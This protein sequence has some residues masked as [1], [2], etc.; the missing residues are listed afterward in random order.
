MEGKQAL[1]QRPILRSRSTRRT[2][3]AKVAMVNGTSEL[4][5]MPMHVPLMWRTKTPNAQAV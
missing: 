5:L 1:V 3:Q 4:L 2:D